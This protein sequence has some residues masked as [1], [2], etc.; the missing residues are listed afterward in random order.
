MSLHN[1]TGSEVGR[2]F[3]PAHGS[4]QT[5]KDRRRSLRDRLLIA[6]GQ[7]ALLAFCGFVL[8]AVMRGGL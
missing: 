6:V 5:F 8:L 3:S 2:A 7:L 4:M 1:I